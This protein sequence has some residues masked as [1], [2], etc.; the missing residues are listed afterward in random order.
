M[1]LR[2]NTSGGRNVI[3]GRNIS[4]WRRSF[5][6]K[7]C[8]QKRGRNIR[9]LFWGRNFEDRFFLRTKCWGQ[10]ALEDEMVWGW[11]NQ[12]EITTVHFF[13]NKSWWSVGSEGTTLTGGSVRVQRHP[14][15][16]SVRRG[17]FYLLTVTSHRVKFAPMYRDLGGVLLD[18]Y[19]PTG[20]RG[21]L[22][23][24]RSWSVGLK[25]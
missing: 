24:H 1:A 4:S 17:K 3:P 18:S 15:Q 20:Q 19:W 22:R 23:S 8:P 5:G 9:P 10:I 2:A 14:S 25:K 16:V 12:D 7:I 13:L 11:N 21:T 6:L